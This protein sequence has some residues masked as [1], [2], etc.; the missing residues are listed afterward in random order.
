M[1]MSLILF[2][3]N[4][5]IIQTKNCQNAK[6]CIFQNWAIAQWASGAFEEITSLKL[7]VSDEHHKAVEDRNFRCSFYI[8]LILLAVHLKSSWNLRRK[9]AVCS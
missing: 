3:S 7:V 8:R 5:F 4:R 6:E 1:E 9:T 2:F